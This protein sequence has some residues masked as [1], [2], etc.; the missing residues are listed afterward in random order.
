MPKPL[1]LEMA[2]P[3]HRIRGHHLIA[4]VA[5]SLSRWKILYRVLLF[6]F[7]GVA[8]NSMGGVCEATRR[9]GD[10]ASSSGLGAYTSTSSEIDFGVPPWIG[11]VAGGCVAMSAPPIGWLCFR[12]RGPYF[13]IVTIV[14][15]AK[16]RCRI[17]PEVRRIR[18]GVPKAPEFKILATPPLDDAVR[19]QGARL[20]YRSSDFLILALTCDVSLDRTHAYRATIWRPLARYED[21][22]E[23]VGVNAPT[24]W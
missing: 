3:L 1:G 18:S 11:M 22:A 4:V 14:N 6:S 21:A 10:A 16:C 19:G 20:L 12:L 5:K 8:C 24:K 7:I 17:L 13:T 23:A 2:G 15:R 9:W